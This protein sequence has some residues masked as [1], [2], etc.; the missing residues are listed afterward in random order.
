MLIISTNLKEA[1]TTNNSKE[2]NASI[3]YLIHHSLVTA[4]IVYIIKMGIGSMLICYLL[5]L[6]DVS[7]IFLCLMQMMKDIGLKKHPLASIFELSFFFLFTTSRIGW[8]S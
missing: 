5:V 3:I 6:Y 4:F 2:I 8:G 1:M 7:T